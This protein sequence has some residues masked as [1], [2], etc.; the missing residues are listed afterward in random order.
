[1][2]IGLL[3]PIPKTSLRTTYLGVPLFFGSSR[4]FHFNR[5]LDSLRA[6]LERWK[7]KYLSFARR[8]I[9]VKHVLSSI[10]LH[11]SLVILIPSKTCNLIESLM[12]NFRWSANSE[13]KRS[14]MVRWETIYLPKL[15]GGLGLP[16]I[17]E[18]NEAC[19]LYLGWFAATSDST[20]ARWFRYRYFRS[21]SIWNPSNP[22]AGS[23]IWKRI[24]ALS[25]FLQRDSKCI[26]GNGHSISLWYDKWIDHDPIASRFPNFQFS[27]KDS[28]AAI[29]KDYSWHIP[30]HPL[31][32]LQAFLQ[33]SIANFA[34]GELSILDTLSWQGNSSGL[35]SLKV[36]WNLLR[37]SASEVNWGRLI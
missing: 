31:A 34:L 19:M 35:F 28:V 24:K 8:L 17:K 10:P 15:E 20:W 7:T 27:I 33:F 21:S 37:S 30:N 3:I 36:A 2:V 6:M 9:L 18:L 32:D 22:V 4:H 26:L 23:C 25:F 14:H 16:R 5:M 13:R 12:R 11:I 1:M 29:I